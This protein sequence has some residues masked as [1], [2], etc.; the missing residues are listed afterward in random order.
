MHQPDEEPTEWDDWPLPRNWQ[1]IARERIVAEFRARAG[2]CE[3][4]TN[5]LGS[6]LWL[7]AA[8]EVE[9]IFVETEAKF[10]LRLDF[11][12]TQP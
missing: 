11:D 4:R 7:E 8:V 6:K 10:L 1:L 9:R 12:V 5:L 3:S 2:A